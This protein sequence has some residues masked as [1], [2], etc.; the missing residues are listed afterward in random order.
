[1]QVA[2]NAR[3][4]FR[5]EKLQC[6]AGCVALCPSTCILVTAILEC[7]FPYNIAFFVAEENVGT[8]SKRTLVHKHLFT[9]RSR[10]HWTKD[11]VRDARVVRSNWGLPDMATVVSRRLGV[12][13]N[14]AYGS[15][16][17]VVEAKPLALV[18]LT[19]LF[20]LFMVN[21][22]ESPVIGVSQLSRPKLSRSSR[23]IWLSQLRR[24]GYIV[25]NSFQRTK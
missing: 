24:L 9:P 6:S 22:V 16:R 13:N 23:I 19:H 2:V 25:T 17:P 11:V 20:L 1:M 21:L 7:S 10:H 8:T 15:A 5:A 12:A 3:A 4:A 14:N 18:S